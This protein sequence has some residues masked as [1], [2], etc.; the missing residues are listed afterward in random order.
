MA[1]ISIYT[2]IYLFFVIFDLMPIKQNKYNKLFVFNLII[3][4]MAFLLVVLVGLEYKLPSPSDLIEN[5]V[6]SI[7]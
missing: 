5:I 7:I 6:R 4:T 2:F 3:L 1:M